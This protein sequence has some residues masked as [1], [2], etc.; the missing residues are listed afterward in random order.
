MP[1]VSIQ[2]VKMFI[3]HY[4]LL[5]TFLIIMPTLSKSKF[6]LL[7][8][9]RNGNFLGHLFEAASKLTLTLCTRA[10]KLHV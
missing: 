6:Q 7:V 5:F 10:Y 3:I 1:S 2:N 4:I 8:I 9:V